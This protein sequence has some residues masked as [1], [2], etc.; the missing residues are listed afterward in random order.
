MLTEVLSGKFAE[1]QPT[2][3]LGSPPMEDV[4]SGGDGSSR[5]FENS[6]LLRALSGSF[7]GSDNNKEDGVK[8]FS[9]SATAADSAL[10]SLDSAMEILTSAEPT[11]TV[12]APAEVASADGS[13]KDATSFGATDEPM[14]AAICDKAQSVDETAQPAQSRDEMA[15]IGDDMAQ[16][17]DD[18]AVDFLDDEEALLAFAEE[19]EREM[20]NSAPFNGSNGKAMRRAPSPEQSAWG[21][22]VSVRAFQEQY[23]LQK[24]AEAGGGKMNPNGK[25]PTGRTA[26]APAITKFFNQPA[27]A[28]PILAAQLAPSRQQKAKGMT[29]FFASAA[30]TGVDASAAQ[31]HGAAEQGEA[32]AAAKSTSVSRDATPP[33]GPTDS[34]LLAEE[35]AAVQELAIESCEK[36]PEEVVVGRKPIIFDDEE[37]QVD[38]AEDDADADAMA[39][40]ENDQEQPPALA[41]DD[42]GPL[43]SASPARDAADLTVCIADKAAPGDDRISL[44]GENQPEKPSSDADSLMQPPAPAIKRKR[45]GSKFFEEEADVSGEDDDGEDEED[46]LR[47]DSILP[48][49]TFVADQD[50]ENMEPGR[51]GDNKV[52]YKAYR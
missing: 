39:S 32:T 5:R 29:G 41:S 11:M 23:S 13:A 48:D 25:P 36:A 1:T 19:A 51:A 50:K 21:A 37:M 26:N 20:N 4:D 3:I 35:D 45:P 16:Y 47:D 6:E 40:N 44:D 2:Q 9:S 12:Q 22:R 52:D 17:D 14:L 31:S 49:C 24:R 46:D 15:Q 43:N 33:V 18:M 27:P 42:T 30:A 7:S 28:N 10:S 8:K 38:D 34:A